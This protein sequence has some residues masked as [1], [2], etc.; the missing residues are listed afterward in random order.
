MPQ[1][2]A[3]IA[4]ASQMPAL[5]TWLRHPRQHAPHRRAKMLAH[6][7]H[8]QSLPER[9]AALTPPSPE[10]SGQAVADI[11]G[12]AFGYIVL[13]G[14]IA[15][16]FHSRVPLYLGAF[17]FLTDG[18][19]IESALASIGIRLEPEMIGQDLVKRFVFWFGWFALLGPLKAS[20]PA[21]LASWL[22]PTQSWSSL[23]GIAILLA[24]VEALTGL[25]LRRALPRLRWE[26][27]P[28]VLI[29]TMIQFAF[30]ALA[31]LVLFGPR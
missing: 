14:V 7:A 19:R 12:D 15:L 28:N 23:A 25:A 8:L 20:V 4:D 9:Q 31:I 30:A 13:F 2:K 18:E 26:I 3:D 17:L 1:L 10:R 11:L 5:P 6:M 21:W 27:R 16:L 24:L 22:P 29:W